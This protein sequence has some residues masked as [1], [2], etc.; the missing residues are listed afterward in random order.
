LA[1]TLFAGAI[2]IAHNDLHDRSY[3]YVTIDGN[4]VRTNKKGF[5]NHYSEYKVGD[6]VTIKEILDDSMY[7]KKRSDGNCVIV[8]L[9]P[10]KNQLFAR[11]L[12]A[13]FCINEG[14]L[15]SIRYW[16]G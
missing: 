9:T 2:M 3:K 12:F 1:F 11:S 7:T 5:K 16:D 13:R 10:A 14:K 8:E 4:I 6:E 15:S